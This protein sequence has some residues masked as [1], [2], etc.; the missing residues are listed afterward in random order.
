MAIASKYGVTPWGRWFAEALS[1]F[2][3]SGRLSRGA[4]YANT[5]K[6]AS[7]NF[8]GRSALAKVQGHS[9]PWY[10]VRI[11]FPPLG[12]DAAKK[13]RSII[14]TEPFLL[15]KLESGELPEELLD[16]IKEKG[17]D[18][19]PRSWSSM[20]RS[21]SCPDWG[22][23]CKHMAAVYYLIA[24]EV[25]RDPR[26]LFKL[27]GVDLSEF[28][29]GSPAEIELTLPPPLSLSFEKSPRPEAP[30]LPPEPP[31]LESYLGLVQSLIPPRPPFAEGEFGAAL[32]EFYHRAAVWNP[33]NKEG[34]S[35]SG[36]GDA[37][38]SIERRFSSAL[39]S[40]DYEGRERGMPF[41]LG[42]RQP[43]RILVEEGSGAKRKLTVSGAV[44]LFLAFEDERGSPGYRFLFYLSRLVSAAWRSSAFV[45]A[46]ALDSAARCLRVVWVPLPAAR[47]LIQALDELGSYDPGLFRVGSAK[48]TMS[49]LSGA[50]TARVLAIA[51]LGEWVGACGFRPSGERAAIKPLVDLFFALSNL[52]VASP[53]ART[54]PR[55]IASWLSVFNLDFGSSKYRYRFSIDEVDGASAARFAL[56]LSVLKLGEAGKKPRAIALMD[57]TKK[58]GD[59]DVLR[60]PAA[61]STYVPEIRR[62]AAEKSVV[63]EEPRLAAFLGDASSVLERLGVEIVLPKALKKALA[64]RLVLNARA[65]S[66]GS[67][68]SYL[69]LDTV[70]H[71]DWRV[72]IG[73]QLLTVA[74]FERLVREKK[75]IVVFREGFVRLDPAEVAR[76]L[77]RAK[78]KERPS[79]LDLVAARLSGDAIF[80]ADAEALA[81]SLFAPGD[82]ILPEALE[83][84]LRPYQERGY[85]WAMA[86]LGSGF[87]CVLAD[88]MGLGKT[89]QAIA[90]IARLAEKGQL[91][92]GALVVAPA[93]L[94]TNWERELAR[95]APRLSVARYH[96]AKRSLVARTQVLVTTYDTASR[97]AEKLA[98]KGFSLLICD[99]AQLMKNA[100]A[101]RSRGVKSIQATR[102]L[103]LSGT[104][105]ENRLEDLRS[106]FDF[107]LPGYLGGA[108]EFKKA[109]RERIEIDR[110]REAA[111][112]LKR[113]TSP[114][115]LRR[116]KTD[117]DIVPDL[118]D[119]IVADEYASLA[120]G[121][122]ALYE[123][124]MRFT[125]AEA[126]AA[127]PGPERSMVVLKL[128]TALK[129]ICDHPRAYDK[130]SP[131]EAK[132]SGKC[133]LLLELLREILDR[134]EKVLVFSQ[135]VEVLEILKAIIADELDEACLLY[136]GGM[137]KKARDAAVDS[138]QNESSSRVML[139]SLKAG[140]LGLNLTAASRVV[141]Y[142]LWYNPA[143][144]NQATDRAFRIG[145]TKNVFVHRLIVAGS[146]EEKIDGMIKAKRELA[147]MSV[148]SGE[149]W[150]AKM[151]MT[152]LREL[153]VR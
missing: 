97:D 101:K 141:H 62:L 70:L 55:A 93:A 24:Q 13:L 116:L 87:G 39:F 56:S 71:Y 112:R 78:G 44:S 1:G 64:P 48:K 77:G 146:F 33:D 109:W 91:G 110:D 43:L 23:P 132:L 30:A 57:A 63:L 4:S 103:A 7:I 129:Q 96:G 12:A 65:K 15:A 79:A 81:A 34:L 138:F 59:F 136:H 151:S 22:D 76:L 52:D 35:L 61:L 106:I 58:L 90:V 89:V 125:L 75:E 9:S 42:N 54:M 50:S 122:A 25:D 83:A 102:R 118:P 11:D 88:D 41:A 94:L 26:I 80:T 84:N 140:G 69:D 124:V 95:F 28:S 86:N 111:E 100:E 147:D 123:S 105:V 49:V 72:A 143:V 117:R 127:A 119:K 45:P 16:R 114:F 5:G 126:E 27:R 99:E 2:D 128:L 14:E 40:V 66:Q 130:E 73:D 3:E 68:T 139:V 8:E 149:S 144:E 6:V 38:D 133:V 120:P 31:E 142:D 134:R 98:G 108:A 29:G 51:C 20:K 150:I 148:S 145:Q 53:G 46:P 121:Q 47:E 135:Y 10:K 82:E 32:V 74:A 113:I 37:V 104:P 17:I 21:C 36:A 18:L 85:R 115:L 153:F 107:V 131:S 152:E 92:G 137:S 67:L 60:I 19:I